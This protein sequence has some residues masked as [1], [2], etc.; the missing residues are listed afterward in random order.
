MLIG[1]GASLAGAGV[2]YFMAE[3]SYQDHKEATTFEDADKYFNDTKKYDN[4]TLI[5]GS[6]G[7]AMIVT[8]IIMKYILGP[9]STAYNPIHDNS[10]LAAGFFNNKFNAIYQIKF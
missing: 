6:A 10:R 5:L 7:G 2:T 3:T 9:P 8:W 4:M 1:G